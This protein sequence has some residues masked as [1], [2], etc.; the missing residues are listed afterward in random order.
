MHKNKSNFLSAEY[1]PN[2][3]LFYHVT[4]LRNQKRS[5]IVFWHIITMIYNM[6]KK[7]YCIKN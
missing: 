2:T 7:F 3:K 5:F 4:I 1:D 6:L